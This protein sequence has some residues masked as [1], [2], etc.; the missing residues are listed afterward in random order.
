MAYGEPN[1]RPN[2]NTEDPYIQPII[3][4]VLDRRGA[5]SVQSL[6]VL[7]GISR[8]HI[9]RKFDHYVGISPKLFCR[10]VRFQ[11]MMRSVASLGNVDWA[12]AA[13]D[14]GYYDQ[15]HMISDFKEFSGLTPAS[16][17]ARR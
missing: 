10:V 6:S 13:L 3:R 5:V 7:A 11:N 16:F 8:Q 1:R 2:S 9:A 17:L 14:L 4:F 15:A 12:S